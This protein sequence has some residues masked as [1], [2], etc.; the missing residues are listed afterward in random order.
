MLEKTFQIPPNDTIVDDL[1]NLVASGTQV[2]VAVVGAAQ[3]GGTID[4][5][6]LYVLDDGYVPGVSPIAIT[7]TIS[8]IDAS[9][10]HI[11]VGKT[12]VDMNMLSTEALS[13]IKAGDTITVLGLLPQVGQPAL[14][15]EIQNR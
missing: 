3:K 10:G 8:K 5:A 4:Q 2:Q 13:L 15:T 1:A 9:T 6:R 12:L 14:A 7:G 11:L